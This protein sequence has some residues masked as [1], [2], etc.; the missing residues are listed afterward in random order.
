MSKNKKGQ[1]SYF[2]FTLLGVA[3]LLIVYGKLIWPEVFGRMRNE[4]VSFLTAVQDS[5]VH[6]TAFVVLVS[7]S[8]IGIIWAYM[9]DRNNR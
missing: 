6:A 1:F 9:K 8:I 4:G 3:F 5:S 2:K 7:C